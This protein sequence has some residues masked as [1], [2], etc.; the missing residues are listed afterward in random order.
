ME[1]N[2]NL[3][4]LL[5]NS[6]LYLEK[7]FDE[8][9]AKFDLFFVISKDKVFSVDVE[10]LERRWGWSFDDICCFLREQRRRKQLEFR[11]NEE[12]DRVCIILLSFDI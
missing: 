3:R 8:M 7:K 10:V 12:E 9:R 4:E 1:I 6:E 5:N 11:F 2:E